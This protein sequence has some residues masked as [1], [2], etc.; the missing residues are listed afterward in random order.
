[1]KFDNVKPEIVDTEVEGTEGQNSWYTSDVEIVVNANDP[2]GVLDGYIYQ[3]LSSAGAVLTPET[4]VKDVNQSIK[5]EPN[6]QRDGI[7]TV[8]IQA[9]DQAGNRSPSRTLTIQKDTENPTIGEP[10]IANIVEN[11]FRVSV[12]AGDVTSGI[13][14]YEYYL[15]GSLA[16]TSQQG[17]WEPSNL[18]PNTYYNV[19]V[20]VYD[21]AGLMKESIAAP[22]TT[23]G[24]LLV[25]NVSISGTQD[26]KSV[27]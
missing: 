12:S 20:R 16:H 3:I 25:P 9:I 27:V 14:R 24:E 18:T 19:T 2:K 8:V 1:M 11:G 22:L 13:D 26:R 21:R 5:N 4:H 23:Q 10:Q 7:Y 6:L 15:N 17:V